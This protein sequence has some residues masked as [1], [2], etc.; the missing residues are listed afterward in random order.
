MSRL[1][2]LFC[3]DK[4]HIIN[5][6]FQKSPF[7]TFIK[8]SVLTNKAD[9]FT[10]T[11]ILITSVLPSLRFIQQNFIFC[12][13]NIILI[14]I[15]QTNCRN[16]LFVAKNISILLLQKSQRKIFCGVFY[17]CCLIFTKLTKNFQNNLIW[18][19]RILCS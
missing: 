18:H 8:K 7:C 12:L 13:R 15:L 17:F 2:S 10:T 5:L 19:L 9:F 11:K 4:R 6:I 1:R 16:K 3:W 14:F